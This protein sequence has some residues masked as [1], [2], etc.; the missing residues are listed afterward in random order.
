[1]TAV[2]RGLQLLGAV[3]L[4][5]GYLIAI[6]WLLLQVDVGAQVADSFSA[7]GDILAGPPSDGLLL[8]VIAAVAWICWLLFFR[9][10]LLEAWGALR[11]RP[12]RERDSAPA[13]RLARLLVSSVFVGSTFVPAAVPA[14]S[15]SLISSPPIVELAVPVTLVHN[16][17][18][19]A[20]AVPGAVSGVPEHVVVRRDTLWGL[21][22]RY[23]GDGTRW[24][25]IYSLN[26]GRRQAD[27][28]SLS[29]PS[30][31]LVG[32][33]LQIPQGTVS[34]V[35]VSEVA[36][37]EVVVPEVAVP[38]AAVPEAALPVTAPEAPPV[39]ET[40]N[41]AEDPALLWIEPLSS[42]GL[43]AE[44]GSA[45]AT[46][47][48]SGLLAGAGSVLAVGL[49]VSL[50]RLRRSRRR[51]YTAQLGPVHLEQR[52]TSLIEDA[53]GN[54]LP[55]GFAT[56]WS[57]LR[58]RGLQIV[59]GHVRSDEIAVLPREAMSMVPP[60]RQRSDGW[61]V[62]PRGAVL[63]SD[64]GAW[65]E[66]LIEVGSAGEQLFVDLMTVGSLSLVGDETPRLEAVV[67]QLRDSPSGSATEILFV[68]EFAGLRH[69]EERVATGLESILGELRMRS[70]QSDQP[71]VVVVSATDPNLG[72]A[73]LECASGL[74]LLV[75]GKADLSCALEL[76]IVDGCV[77]VTPGAAAGGAGGPAVLRTSA[78]GVQLS[79]ADVAAI[80]ELLAHYRAVGASEYVAPPSPPALDHS[81]ATVKLLLLGEVDIE[82]TRTPLAPQQ[83]AVVTFLHLHPGATAETLQQAVWGGRPPSSQRFKNVMSEIRSL[84]GHDA[85]P[86]A[87]AGR[88][89]LGPQVSSDLACFEELR[90]Q[91]DLASAEAA[92]SLVRGV[93]LTTSGVSRRHFGW[94]DLENLSSHWE[95]HVLRLGLQTVDEF[96]QNG[97]FNSAV[98][99][100]RHGLLG[101]PLNEEL[102]RELISAHIGA[103]QH[104]IAANVAHELVRA[105][106]ELGVAELEP[107]T[108]ALIAPLQA[109]GAPG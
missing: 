19:V 64:D 61:W 101:C 21:A 71:L 97:D 10:L 82:G 33:K 35:A 51:R 5:L 44:E 54:E 65:P 108:E 93:P 37:S 68:G 72:A 76:R 81:E 107:E 42:A 47:G 95:L 46:S 99:A 84:L 30:L 25:E 87:E 90:S 52:L 12:L 53:T 14:L 17:A 34:E 56:F 62:A 45:V 70:S 63:G 1:M 26:Q 79:G 103:G 3:I 92:L 100:A 39:V 15:A 89:R 96:A 75:I 106:E 69:P 91:Q 11:G 43:E 77:E 22:E 80:H 29:D 31:I 38:E 104:R 28:L 66:L 48:V 8:G 2:R 6:P 16:T 88:Y 86:V 109:I 74:C 40:Q 36:V 55:V 13:R 83:L 102:T 50:D 78:Q 4:L 7:P 60:W 23:L 57:E 73:I 85:F 20:T 49:A 105:L 27:G 32:W 58:E 24:S 9:L 18:E 59:C 67:Q 41:E 94:V 98:T